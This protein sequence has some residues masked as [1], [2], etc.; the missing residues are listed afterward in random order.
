MRTLIL[1]RPDRVGDVV[2]STSCLAPVRET[3]PGAKIYF[4]AAERMRP[5][6]EN[7]PLLAGFISLA[8]DLA[9]EFKRLQPSAMV[10]LHPDRD[11][12]AAADRA[13]VPVRIGYPIRHQSRLLTHAV[14]DRRKEG[15]Q[16]E[17][18]YNFD[19]LRA[20]DVPQ[21]PK[22]TPVIHLSETSRDSLQKKLPWK[23]EVTRFV[24]LNPTAHSKFA[25]WPASRFLDLAVRLKKEFDLL[26]VFIGADAD[27]SVP[28]PSGSCL[29]LAGKTDLGEL[30]WLLKH[31][32]VTVTNDTGP[33]HLA[34]AVGCPLVTL[35]GRTAALY[36]PV[37]WRP[38]TDKA[39]VIAHPLPTRHFERR[40]T[41]WQRCFAA[42]SVDEAAAGVREAMAL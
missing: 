35:F 5:L 21:P 40:T 9:L 12:Y 22:F 33:S 2:I 4:V 38:L 27:D 30:G 37:R 16:H 8:G 24:V 34:A 42:I 23:L 7:H 39:V 15:L 29:N 14:P 19:L 31:A 41:H 20:L 11:C 28:H 18:A 36:G 6:L 17:A 1:S 26:P 25:R 10:H 3:F 32:A 13:G